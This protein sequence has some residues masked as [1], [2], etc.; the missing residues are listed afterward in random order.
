MHSC[1]AGPHGQFR[2]FIP[3]LKRPRRR[4][5]ALISEWHLHALGGADPVCMHPP[6]CS[7]PPPLRTRAQGRPAPLRVCHT[8]CRA[9]HQWP[10]HKAEPLMTDL[11]ARAPRWVAPASC[12]LH[13]PTS[14]QHAP[15]PGCARA[16]KVAPRR[17]GCMRLCG[18]PFT[19]P[20]PCCVA[21]RLCD[22]ML[23]RCWAAVLPWQYCQG[24]AVQP[25]C[26][27]LCISSVLRRREAP[28]R[29]YY[30]YFMYIHHLNA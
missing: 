25:G 13:T 21:L 19:L 23:R 18:G 7:I 27:T 9:P 6:R 8:P 14:L 24:S 30:C 11:R 20:V 3:L 1:T 26:T 12:V 28:H 10:T 5:M 17:R 15:G 22:A 29:S 2:F 4:P 16:R